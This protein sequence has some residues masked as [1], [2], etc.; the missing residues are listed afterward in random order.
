MESG[1]FFWAGEVV[2]E[3]AP[4][5][6]WL[7]G[8]VGVGGVVPCNFGWTFVP[9]FL[10]TLFLGDLPGDALDLE[11]LAASLSELSSLSPP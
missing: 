3:L 1:S 7:L 6:A 4:A 10:L 9:P 5:R 2:G 8:V 11:L